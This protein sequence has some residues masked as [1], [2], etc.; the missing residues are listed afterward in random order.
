MRPV[1]RRTQ[2]I[3]YTFYKVAH[4][5]TLTIKMLEMLFE[6]KKALER[7]VVLG[8]DS[9]HCFP[10]RQMFLTSNDVNDIMR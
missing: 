9:I 1:L 7:L 10:E 5:R 3:R 4:L 2:P 8:N 6:S